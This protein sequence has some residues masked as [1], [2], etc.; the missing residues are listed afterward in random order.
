VILVD[1]L[2]EAVSIGGTDNTQFFD[3]LFPRLLPGANTI[4]ESYT[5]GSISNLALS[6]NNRWF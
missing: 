5:L 2:N 6:W 3:G 1:S 4:T